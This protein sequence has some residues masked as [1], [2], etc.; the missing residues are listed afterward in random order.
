LRQYWNYWTIMH[1]L[2]VPWL[3]GI[4][5]FGPVLVRWRERKASPLIDIPPND[6]I[7]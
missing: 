2:T 3:F 4:P 7:S 1:V 6:V 5:L